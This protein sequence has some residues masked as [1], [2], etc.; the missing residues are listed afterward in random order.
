VSKRHVFGHVQPA[1][2][3]ILTLVAVA[4]STGDGDGFSS[5]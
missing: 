3:A 2:V 5:A 4:L 1:H